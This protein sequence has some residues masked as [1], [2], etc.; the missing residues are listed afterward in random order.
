VG[1]HVRLGREYAHSAWSHPEHIQKLVHLRGLAG[2]PGGGFDSGSHFRHG[3]G[4]ML[5]KLGFDRRAVWVEGTVRPTRLE[6]FQRLDSL[7]DI[8]VAITMEAR[9][10]HQR[11]MACD[12]GDPHISA[13]F[14]DSTA[15]T[16]PACR[17]RLQ[18]RHGIGTTAPRTPLHTLGRIATGLDFN[19]AGAITFFPPDGFAWFHID[20]GPAGGRPIGRLRCS[21]GGNPGDF[22]VISMLQNGNVGIG[23]PAPAT[24]LHVTGARIRLQKAGTTQRLDLRADGGALDIESAG[25][26]LYINNN[27]LSVRIRNLVQG[28]SREWQEEIADLLVEAAIDVLQHLNPISFVFRE[29]AS[30]QQHLGFVAEELPTTVATQDRKGF[31]PMA[32]IAVLTK[33]VKQQQ[34]QIAGLQ[35]E[36]IRLKDMGSSTMQTT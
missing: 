33:V 23:T 20:N 15:P 25:A 14:Q 8:G 2:I 22:E 36:I 24:K 16:L 5:A 32:I 17:R 1:A 27:N 13:W 9:F 19:S 12:I 11:S 31:S 18:A 3:G 30:H 35:E 28:S 4:R 7:A 21:Y 6:V 34:Q 26:D 29:D 10:G